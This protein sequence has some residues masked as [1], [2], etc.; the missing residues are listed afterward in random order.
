PEDPPGETPAPVSRSCPRTGSPPRQAAAIPP[1]RDRR[2]AADGARPSCRPPEPPT[3]P[4]VRTNES[5]RSA[6]LHLR[7]SPRLSALR[8]A[9]EL[10]SAR[11]QLLSG[12]MMS[13]R[14]SPQGHLVLRQGL[15]RKRERAK[16][17]NE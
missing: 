2:R 5:P 6:P 3:V 15:A 1:G 14:V 11:L 13:L 10:P 9:S 16:T 17:R 8:V 4:P 7:V 12:A